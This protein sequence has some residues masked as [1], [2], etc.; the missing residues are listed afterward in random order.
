MT[1]ID[2]DSHPNANPT[3]EVGLLQVNPRPYHVRGIGTGVSEVHNTG[4]RR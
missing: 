4:A 2:V 1:W 3:T